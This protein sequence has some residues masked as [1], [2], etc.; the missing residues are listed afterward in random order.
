M[1]ET[2]ARGQ[3]RQLVRDRLVLNSEI[4]LPTLTNE[5][6]DVIL[7]DPPL[8]AKLVKEVLRDMVYDIAQRT[9]Q[10]TRG[11]QILLG[12]VM[13]TRY[14][15]RTAAKLHP[16]FTEWY[17]H[18]GDRHIKLMEMTRADLLVAASER[19]MRG[20]HEI[21]I[22]TVW[23]QLASKLRGAQKVGEKFTEE[24]IQNIK[25]AVENS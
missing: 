9:M 24:D 2:S 18:V 22:A 11:K 12:D 20:K 25:D 6:V 5:L 23:R 15:V 17:E 7:A 4:W 16:A 19:E 1:N 3:I 14:G 21:V 8:L 10:E 13:T